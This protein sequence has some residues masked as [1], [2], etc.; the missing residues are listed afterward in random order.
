MDVGGG[1]SVTEWHR[2][3]YHTIPARASTVRYARDGVHGGGGVEVGVR[4]KSGVDLE[5]WEQVRSGRIG[6]MLFTGRPPKRTDNARSR[7]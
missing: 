1:S 6:S 4:D 2:W 3:S 5:L 7:R